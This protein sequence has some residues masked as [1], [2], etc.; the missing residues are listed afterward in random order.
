MMDIRRYLCLLL[1]SL[2][3]C[4]SSWAKE[5]KDTLYSPSGDR[6]ILGYNMTQDGG[7]VTVKFGTV[8]KKLSKRTQEK[9]KK[10]DEVAVVMFDRTGNYR[11]LKFDGQTP[12]AFMVQA[13]VSYTP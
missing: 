9:Y 10:L 4:T 6:V 7:L 8:Q 5:E 1:L 12:N 13:A 3:V 2:T 11:D